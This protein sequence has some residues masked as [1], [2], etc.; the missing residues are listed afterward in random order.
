MFDLQYEDRLRA[1]KDFRN[2]IEES[3][4]PLQDTINFVNQAPVGKL[5]LNL[6]S[7]TEWPQPWNLNKASRFS[8]Q[9]K[10][11]RICYT[12]QLTER[13]ATEDVDI[14]LGNRVEST[15][16]LLFLLY[17]GEYVIGYVYDLPVPIKDIS[18]SLV[19][20]RIYTMPRLQ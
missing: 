19:S 11:L 15:D 7:N 1:W 4:K 3:R 6:W 9:A 13:Y 8:E 2:Y 5:E 18:K 17:F 16:D 14:D 10:S 12:L 20:Q